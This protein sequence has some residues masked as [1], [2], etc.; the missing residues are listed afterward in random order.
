MRSVAQPVLYGDGRE[1]ASIKI[2]ADLRLLSVQAARRDSIHLRFSE[3][4]GENRKDVRLTLPFFP[5]RAA[6]QTMNGKKIE[7]LRVI[8][9][10]VLFSVQGGA[11][12]TLRVWGDF[13]ISPVQTTEEAISDVFSVPV[14]NTRAIVCFTKAAGLKAKGFRMIGEGQVLAVIENEPERVQTAEIPVRPK[15]ILIEPQPN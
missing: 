2:S 8:N 14:E 4:K 3:E 5:I 13:T 6:M 9:G 1:A 7:P 10:E 15:E 12:A 11:Y